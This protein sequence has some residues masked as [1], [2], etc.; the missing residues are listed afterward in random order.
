L[1]QLDNIGNATLLHGL[2]LGGLVTKYNNISTVGNGVPSILTTVDLLTQGAS[3][4]S[5]LLYAIPASGGGLYRIH[6]YSK[7]TRASSGTSGL[8][9]LQIVFT[10]NSDST[11]LTTTCLGQNGSGVATTNEGGL[12]TTT[13]YVGMIEIWAKSSTNINYTFLYA[14]SGITSMQYELHIKLEYVG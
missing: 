2:I 7:V 3:I 12:P 8:G 10:D 4:G 11:V 5:T 1:F 14:S 9:P 13:Q 6:Y